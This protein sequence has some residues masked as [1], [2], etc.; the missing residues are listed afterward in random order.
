[1][2]LENIIQP[3]SEDKKIICSP[4]YV[5]FRSRANATMLLDLDPKKRGEHIWEV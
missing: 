1:M 4:S 2:E 3:G 5:G